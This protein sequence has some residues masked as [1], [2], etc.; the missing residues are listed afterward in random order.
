MG[1]LKVKVKKFMVQCQKF[2][3]LRKDNSEKDNFIFHLVHT[4]YQV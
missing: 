3:L 1:A 4:Q 2:S